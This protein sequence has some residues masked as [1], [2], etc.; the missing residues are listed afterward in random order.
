[1]IY[2]IC[3][4]E[5]NTVKMHRAAG[6]D[7]L[8]SDHFQTELDPRRPF[9]SGC[10]RAQILCDTTHCW[11]LNRDLHA[12]A[13]EEPRD[14]PMLLD[15]GN[16]ILAVGH[17]LNG[18]SA[19]ANVPADGRCQCTNTSRLWSAKTLASSSMRFHGLLPLIAL[20][21]PS[22]R[23]RKKS[24]V[25]G[26]GLTMLYTPLVA[27]E[28]APPAR[29]ASWAYKAGPLLDRAS[30]SCSPGQYLSP[31][32]HYTSSSPADS[33][34]ATACSQHTRIA[35]R[36]IQIAATAG[37]PRPLAIPL[38][39]PTFP[40]SPMPMSTPKPA[41]EPLVKGAAPRTPYPNPKF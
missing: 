15:D 40:S 39:S 18:E 22:R 24:G 37:P 26:G 29:D 6:L 14:A 17:L 1:M 25:A 36:P 41:P 9:A 20:P 32:P 31:P 21:V 33:L 16:E 4:V 12:C 5:N 19:L 3:V 11:R 27:Y 8:G 23:Q 35:P 13:A 38:R 7:F 28:C 34:V 2:R 30:S 10:W